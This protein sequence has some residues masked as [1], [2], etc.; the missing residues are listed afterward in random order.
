M[1]K[2]I[3]GRS[4]PFRAE[5]LYYCMVKHRKIPNLPA[6]KCGH[7]DKETRLDR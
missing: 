3:P 7:R 5:D 6:T 2:K 1:I 4:A